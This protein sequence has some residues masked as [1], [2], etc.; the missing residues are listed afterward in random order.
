MPLASRRL[1]LHRPQR[2]REALVRERRREA[3][4]A[5][6]IGQRPELRRVVRGIAQRR[7]GGATVATNHG[8]G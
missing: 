1:R 2:R 3:L 7:H 4:E 8:V 6:G 5:S